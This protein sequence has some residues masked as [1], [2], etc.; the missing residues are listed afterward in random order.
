MPDLDAVVF[1]MDGTLFDS[2]QVVP[3][4]FADTIRALGG[5]SLTRE[6]VIG[7]Y[8]IGPPGPIMAHFLGRPVTAEE[9]DAYHARLAEEAAAQRLRP[10]PGV[11]DALDALA[12]HVA[13]GVFTNADTGNAAVLLG[14]AGLRDRFAAVVGADEVAPRFKPEPDGLLLA[15]ERLG[16]RAARTAYVGDSPLDARVARRAGAMAV[17]AAWGHLHD[18]GADADVV[19]RDPRRLPAALAPAGNA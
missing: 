18:D 15:C 19:V 5:P 7:S 17:A 6:E 16:V 1:D 10:Y 14:A 2:S 4:A 8:V 11:E 3:A 13:L 12:P 9:L